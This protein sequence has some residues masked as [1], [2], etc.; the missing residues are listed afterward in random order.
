MKRALF[1]L[2]NLS[3]VLI[4][5]N[6]DVVSIGQIDTDALLLSQKIDLYVS[7]QGEDGDNI[8]NLKL[9]NFRVY[10]SVDGDSFT[11]APKLLSLEE[12]VNRQQGVHM[13]LLL[14]NSGSMYDKLAGEPTEE[15]DAMRM[16]HAKR[17][18]RSFVETSFLPSDV[19]SLAS[20]NTDI[21]LHSRAIR[22]PSALDA[23][24]REIERPE[25][26]QAYTEL[27]QSLI[28]TADELAGGRGRKAVVV[29][30]DGENYPFY[31]H[32]G[33]PHSKYGTEEKTPAQAIKAYQMEGISLYAIHFGIEQDRYLGEIAR[34]T[35]GA[36]Y[37]ARNEEELAEVYGDIKN[38]IENE[39]RLSY[40]AGM[41][42]AEKTYVRVA[43]NRGQQSADSTRRYFTGTILGLPMVPFNPMIFLSIVAA[44][45]LWALIFILRYR[46]L[47]APAMLSVMQ[48]GFTTKVSARTIP[49]SQEKTVIGGDPRA[50][51]TISGPSAL[52]NEHASIIKDPKS[53]D[54]TLIGDGRIEVNNQALQE[55]RRLEDGDVISIE[56][57]T[58]VFE[59][60]EEKEGHPKKK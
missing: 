30:S 7:V 33:E 31:I 35:G 15:Q 47:S 49:L 52:K 41:L 36:V 20:F 46:K 17:A 6:A 24:L 26:R 37:D 19:I 23:L 2:W 42:P 60:E 10:E 40:R 16:S 51:L 21:R 54:Y 44:L 29:L 22:D 5:T 27:Y 43:Y 38:K 18:L 14:D 12:Q 56:G 59:K 28:E 39:Y 3:L 11:E 25:G 8:E 55:A 13:M 57:T 58:I 50:D 4:M 48:A 9:D 34:Q 53:G 45:T 32:T 1:F